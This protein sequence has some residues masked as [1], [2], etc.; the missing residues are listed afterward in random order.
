MPLFDV[1]ARHRLLEQCEAEPA[2]DEPGLAVGELAQA[3]HQVVEDER[4]RERH[5]AE[6][7]YPQPAQHRDVAEERPEACGGGDA[8]RQRHPGRE[9]QMDREHHGD[10]AGGPGERVEAQKK[11]LGVPEDQ[12]ESDRPGHVHQRERGEP[13]VIGAAARDCRHERQHERKGRNVSVLLHALG[14]FM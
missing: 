13:H 2:A 4:E 1:V 14:R 9:L 7:D 12:V 10:V 8:D 11:L 3:E 6:E 5:D